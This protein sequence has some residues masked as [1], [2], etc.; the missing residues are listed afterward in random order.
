MFGSAPVVGTITAVALKSRLDGGEA[1]TVLDVREDDER[2][3]SAIRL[4]TTARD[5]H[6]PMNFVSG[7]LDELR[8][9]VGHEPLVVYCH[10][11]VRSMN[12]ARWLVRQ[13]MAGVHNLAGGID[14]WSESVDPGVPRY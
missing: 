4:P 14:A 5:L 11:G 13:G 1:L 9:L 12:V 6:I 2:A 8:A 7:R 10:H 3:F